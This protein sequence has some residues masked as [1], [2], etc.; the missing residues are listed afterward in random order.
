MLLQRRIHRWKEVMK[1]SSPTW[2]AIDRKQA[3]V[4]VVAFRRLLRLWHLHQFAGG[5][6]CVVRLSVNRLGA[7]RSNQGF[8]TF[9]DLSIENPELS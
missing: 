7:L 1:Q 9:E 6:C 5:A 4:W 2:P 8:E 3:G